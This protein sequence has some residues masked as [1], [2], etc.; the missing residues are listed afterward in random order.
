MSDPPK[1]KIKRAPTR[2]LT[3]NE[4]RP[5]AKAAEP[6][7]PRF[8]PED[9]R[10]L[11]AAR[12]F[13]PSHVKQVSGV[14]I[15]FKV[16]LQDPLLASAQPKKAFDNKFYVEWEPGLADGPTS[17][18]FAV[19]DYN[20]DTGKL[21]PPATWDVKQSKF[22]YG[23]EV[24]DDQSKHQL[25]FHQVNVWAL[26]Q[27]ALDFFEEGNGLGRR[28]PWGFEGN[29]LIVVPHAGYGENA[30][31]DRRSK[32]LQF[33]Y[34]GSEADT[35]YT[36]VSTDIVCHEF[37]HAVL[38]GIRP[39]YNETI[40]VQTAAFHEAIGDITAILL[41]LR[42]NAFRQWLAEQTEG[43]MAKAEP[44]GFIAEQFG[45]AVKGK[46]YLRSA[47]NDD[48]MSTVAGRSNSAH[49]VSEVLVGA[50]FEILL[51]FADHYRT[52]R[53][54][55]PLQAFWDVAARMQ[56]MA[57]QPLDLLPPVEVTYR[58]YALAVIRAE[59]LANPL[60]PHNYRDLLIR[61]FRTREILTAEDEE[62]LSQ[63]EY[64]YDRPRL[65]ITCD[66]DEIARSRAAAYRFI[67][68]NREELFIPPAQDIVLADL[69]DA[70]KLARQGV[71]LPRQ[72][73]VQYF[74]REDVRLDGPQFGKFDGQ[75][76]TMLCGGTLVF[77]DKGN[78]MSWMRKPGTQ[79]G[80]PRKEQSDKW[81]E[82][83]KAGEER[84]TEFLATIAKQVAAGR[85]GSISG[86]EKGLLGTR[87]PPITAE[88]DNGAVRFQL[89][90]HLHLSEDHHEEDDSGARLWEISC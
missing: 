77:D 38:D 12:R 40:S 4:G 85:V 56:R 88:G 52:E 41:S 67:D 86:S 11:Y 25:Q 59:R 15:P 83:I 60:D 87:V 2:K 79:S 49:R 29:R 68:N 72:V 63:P 65:S 19:V 89:S 32:S 78:V 47:F 43:N 34:F 54:R 37:G 44:L 17:A 14:Q 66:I 36:C 51:A 45:K 24:L 26:L 61:I 1:S 55:T 84:R 53:K 74:W 71:P 82:E 58:D 28:I 90:P 62:T 20:G 81:S 57:I 31:Y 6:M 23:G 70:H 16:Y 50:M 76:T 5:A 9:R 80:K 48:K 64:L 3:A 22:V 75:S 42:N 30:F 39:Y 27:R 33:Y 73:V 35:V 69:Y 10:S 8:T 18:R 7:P 46:P 21:T 13:L